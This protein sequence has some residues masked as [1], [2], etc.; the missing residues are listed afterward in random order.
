MTFRVPDGVHARE[1]D[2]DLVIL[3]SAGDRYFSLN[4]S[5]VVVWR[6]LSAGGTVD[7]AVADLVTGYDI[8]EGTAR[9]DVDAVVARLTG[10]GL[11]VA[12]D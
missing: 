11:L 2:R 1:V 5:G 7:E 3:D 9:A 8:P 6:R 4:E 12:A 10:S